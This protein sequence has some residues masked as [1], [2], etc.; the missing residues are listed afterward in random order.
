MYQLIYI[1]GCYIVIKLEI[2]YNYIKN[3]VTK[4]G[5]GAKVI[6]PKQWVDKEVIVIPFD[7]YL[8][9]NLDQV[10]KCRQFS[11][12]RGRRKR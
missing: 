2:D 11:V 9:A 3:K 5:N 7:V 12:L 1:H 4:H 6:V 8:D 10:M